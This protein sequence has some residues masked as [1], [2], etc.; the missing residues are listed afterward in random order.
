M[1]APAIARTDATAPDRLDARLLRTAFVLVLGPILALLD[2]TI[3]N[4]G[5]DAVARDLHSSLG[6]VQWISAGYLLA[7]SMVMPLSGWATERFGAKTMWMTS[8]GL[9]VAGSALCG[10]A[11]ST[12]S[13]IAFRVV[14]G[15]GGGMIQPIGQSMLV[16]AAGPSRLGRIISITV[17]PITFAPVLGPVLGGL[18]LQNLDWRWM[19]LVNV[20]IGLLTLTLAARMLPR[21]EE[22]A[23][24]GGRSAL[25]PRGDGQRTRLG[26]WVARLP[27][28][29][30]RDVAGRPGAGQQAL[31][32]VA[33]R[34]RTLAGV[35][36][37]SSAGGGQRTRGGGGE[38]GRLDLLGLVL[39]SP[40]LA[41]IVYG[42]S[43][44]GN[45]GGFGSA[46]VLVTLV[47][48]WLLVAGYVAHALRM[49]GTPL[50]D[51]RLFA[52]RGFAVA[53]ANSFLQ[54]AALYSSMLL[55]PLYYQQVEHASAL[56]AGVMLAPQ[57]LGTAVATYFA[58]R[59]TD[60]MAP[61]PLIL[62][63][64]LLTLA[65]TAAFT[66]LGSGPAGWLLLVSLVVRGVGLGV[67][68][69]PGMAAI[70]SAVEKHEVSRAAGAVNTL[71]RVGGALGTAI[72]AV[73]LQGNLSGQAP[74]VAFGDTFWW[75]MG[76]SVIT[77]VP[78]LF[79]PGRTK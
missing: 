18:V 54:G 20:P 43:E 16:R 21:D 60:R 45:V 59:L 73:V 3:V 10:L 74:A 8:V 15:I 13:L 22:R 44:A 69:A 71:N 19:F 33:Q 4:V 7:I 76:L 26:R 72:L 55:L 41:G 5:I 75:A 39:L 25:M 50:I 78:A 9:F 29:A 42:F 30:A 23:L 1:T 56:E 32:R 38:R 58:G 79:Y 51:L 67:V 2:T 35:A 28:A 65:G 40:G 14:Q 64:I 61:R 52:R 34:T 49:D 11:W 17:L 47:G 57:A 46:R 27:F 63:G 77:L 68:M 62:G 36:G 12:G 53:T 70:Y 37:R 66:Q 24:V 48:G 6:S 31:P